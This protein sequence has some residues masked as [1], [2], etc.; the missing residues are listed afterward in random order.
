LLI[1][2]SLGVLLSAI[3]VYLRDMQHMLELLLL[4]WFWGTPIVWYWGL[5]DKVGTHRAWILLL[6]PVTSVTITFQRA[7]YGRMSFKDATGAPHRILPNYTVWQHLE[8]LGV[9]AACS[10]AVLYLALIVFGRLEG[11][12]AEEL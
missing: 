11:N 9:V 7:L 1:A 3:N 6:N 12:F 5:L 2:A 4:A 10:L 8:L